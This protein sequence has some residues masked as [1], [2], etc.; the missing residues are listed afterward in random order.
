[1]KKLI[2]LFLVL[3]AT[4][5][6]A[7]S[8]LVNLP[9][10]SDLVDTKGNLTA[11]G[12]IRN[13]DATYVNTAGALA[14]S[15]GT[16]IN[17]LLY[18]EDTSNAAWV[19]GTVQTVAVALGTYSLAVYKTGATLTA[20][21]TTAAITPLVG[22]VASVGT[23]IYFT[24]TTAGN[25]TITTDSSNPKGSLEKLP[26]GNVIGS[27]LVTNGTFTTDANWTKGGGATAWTIDAADSNKAE[28][29]AGDAGDLAT[30]AAIA[31]VALDTYQVSFVVERTAGTLTPKIGAVSGAAVAAAGTYIQYIKAAAENATLT[32]SADAAFAG[33]LDTVTVKSVPDLAYLSP[34][35][36]TATTGE[37]K[38][39]PAEPRFEANGLLVEGEGTNLLPYSSFQ[40]SSVWS[41]VYFRPDGTTSAWK[42]AV[43]STGAITASVEDS[44]L[45]SGYKI[46]VLTIT[47]A[48]TLDWHC[49]FQTYEL[50]N[51]FSVT[52][53]SK[54]TFS[55]WVYTST[56]KI[57]PISIQNSGEGTVSDVVN[58]TTTGGVWEKKYVTLT[59]SASRALVYLYFG[60]GNLGTYTFK[61]DLPQLE[62]TAYPT[63][64]IPTNGCPVTRL[65]EAGSASNGYSWTMSTA[66]KNSLGAAS[67]SRGTLLVDYT[68]IGS[69]NYTTDTGF[70]SPRDGISGPAY[71]GTNEK[72]TSYDGVNNSTSVDTV[73]T[74]NTF[75][76]ISVRWDSTVSAPTT[77]ALKVS[78]KHAGTWSHGT[79]TNY[80]GSFTLGTSLRL[81][82]GNEYP[83]W[84]KNIKFFDGWVKDGN[85]DHPI[86]LGMFPVLKFDFGGTVKGYQY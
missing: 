27:D 65:T 15:R 57:I 55:F 60:L 68:P 38:T 78:E 42:Y 61:M 1:M 64:Y 16:R 10:T 19:G 51:G 59:P 63:S 58:I 22:L 26:S 84:I 80:D 3:L 67:P 6:F 13:S 34:G 18:S 86:D 52:S 71:F 25:I 23:P 40:S 28:K 24:V 36:Y 7:G 53:A 14:Y 30:A 35:T 4:S 31:T 54:I 37:T 69:Y 46:P 83:F 74:G 56:A 49:S 43:G 21:A 29:G 44:I 33:S 62:A 41:T 9:L 77:G 5:A 48:G 66:L 32:F 17:S 76:T 70:I 2:A 11:G 75:Y 20:A 73:A 39:I 72:L 81:A 50:N 47:N 79:A 45:R 12:L 82:Y 85:L 8:Q